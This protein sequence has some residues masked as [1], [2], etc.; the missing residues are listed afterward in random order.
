[1]RQSNLD[2]SDDDK[3][4]DSN[5]LQFPNLRK[6]LN[7]V[8]LVKQED[9]DN[10]PTV[11]AGRKGLQN[12][13]VK[14][15]MNPDQAM[16]QVLDTE[17]LARQ[18]GSISGTIQDIGGGAE[19]VKAAQDA[20]KAGASAPTAGGLASQ[21]ILNAENARRLD[22]IKQMAAKNAPKWGGQ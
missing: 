20:L 6:A 17:N 16:K 9:I 13:Y 1:M 14:T 18:A 11:Q 19:A 10:N 22:L 12:L 2:D 5:I 8:H 21:Q 7:A 4:S 15:G 3:S